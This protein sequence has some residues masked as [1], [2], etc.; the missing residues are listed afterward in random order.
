MYAPTS[1]LRPTHLI[2]IASWPFTHFGYKRTI[3]KSNMGSS[4]AL[5]CLLLSYVAILASCLS[6]S[7]S[8]E[9]LHLAKSRLHESLK[10]LSG[11]LTLSPEIEIPEPK[12][13]T[14]VLLLSTAITQLSTLIRTK[15]KAN[16]AF[17]SGSL[18]AVQMFC[19]EQ[20]QARGG[21]PGPIPVVY[22]GDQQDDWKELAESG[23]CGVLIPCNLDD[24]NA[25][26]SKCELAI[27]VGLQPLPEVILPES[28]VS[29]WTEA[30]FMDDLVSKLTDIV[31][32]EPASVF[33]TIQS[34]PASEENQDGVLVALPPIN[35]ELRKRLP[36]LGSISVSPGGGRMGSE[37]KRFK[38]AGYT[39]AVL[40][41]G[42]LPSVFTDDL[43]LVSRF[44]ASCIGDL[45]STKSKNFE[46]RTRNYMESNA[47][48]DWAKY[49]K[50]VIE[51]GALGSEEHSSI[52]S[53]AGDYQGF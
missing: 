15:A 49:Q 42:C 33:V 31:G 17:L 3:T 2:A 34:S 35:K 1:D 22:C 43:L 16:A 24:L 18:T 8:S 39:G 32:Q 12:D 25:I 9:T 19:N 7:S 51:S 44:W 14:A 13:P 37:T 20:E 38:D 4:P 21:F 5:R 52:N 50:S 41:A 36:I 26:K 47:S 30:N 27:Q 11:K 53:D 6:T 48:L 45:K 40:R 46:F 29:S 23:V 28:E 10:S